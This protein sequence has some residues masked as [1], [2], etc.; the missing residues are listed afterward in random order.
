MFSGGVALPPPPP[1]H[2]RPQVLAGP[3]RRLLVE[4]VTSRCRS[5]AGATIFAS[6]HAAPGEAVA[7]EESERSEDGRSACET[8]PGEPSS[9]G[10]GSPGAGWDRVGLVRYRSLRPGDRRVTG[11]SRI[12]RMSSDSFEYDLLWVHGL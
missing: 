10:A 12:P 3:L 9:S 11:P 5:T 2:L 4:L 1:H 8:R 6:V 7:R